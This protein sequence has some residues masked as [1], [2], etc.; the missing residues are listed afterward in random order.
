VGVNVPMTHSQVAGV[1]TAVSPDS[2]TQQDL[3]DTFAITDSRIRSL[4]LNSAIQ[5]RHLSLPPPDGA[6]GRAAETQGRL[7]AKDRSLA[8]EMGA[9]A[10]EECLKE[11]GA[12]LYDLVT[13]AA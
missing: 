13:C 9:R 3:L 4:F 10:L 6:G 5:R 12:Q 8:V 1:G 11:A 2:Y 7:L